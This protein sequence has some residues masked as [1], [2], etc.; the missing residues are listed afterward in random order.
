MSAPTPQTKPAAAPAATV[1]KPSAAALSDFDKLLAKD[2]KTRTEYTAFQ[3]ETKVSLSVEIVRKYIAVPAK[4]RDSGETLPDD[5][6]CMKFILLCQAR[7][8]NPHEGDAFM[9]PF[10]NKSSGRHEWSLITAHNAFLKRAE[11]HPDYNGK[12]SGVIVLDEEADRIEELQ[13]DFVP[14][15]R[16]L[17]GGWCKV[18]YKN[19]AHPEYQRLKLETY[20]KGFGNWT[21]DAAG[22]ICKCSEAAALRS[23]FPNT[24]AGMYLR[25]EMG[26]GELAETTPQPMAR[27]LFSTP[28]K[29]PEMPQDEKQGI[30]TP[31]PA[32]KPQ[33]GGKAEAVAG[34]KPDPKPSDQ[35]VNVVKSL[36][37]ASKIKESE[38]LG[39]LA[40]I[41]IADPGC[42]NLEELDLASETA[43]GL[44]A[45]QW[46]EF[47]KRVLEARANPMPE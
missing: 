6:Q 46:T 7:R 31:P 47:S 37:K 5:R 19:K 8:L 32:S 15:G 13:G 34:E 4:D 16:T 10:W 28:A 43:M 33:G 40:D 30:Q 23:A 25:E 44:I 14:P 41:G 26:N 20:A 39:F 12:E 45:E 18:H 21:F 22:M 3:S 2:T 42:S 1:T 35:A 38:L 9:I 27:P 36:L 11:V 17:L 29:P 24:M